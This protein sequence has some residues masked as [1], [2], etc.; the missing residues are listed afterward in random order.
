MRK[1]LPVLFALLF[2]PTRAQDDLLSLLGQ[3]S[4][5][6]EYTNASFKTTR[7]INAHSLENTAHGVLDARINHRFGLLSEGVGNFFGLDESTI[8]IGFDYGVTDRLM[9][10]IG[11]SS[12][13]KTIDG[14][15]KYKILRQCDAGC[16]M[17]VTLAVVASTAVTT[18][19]ADEVPWYE[20]GRKDYFSHRLSY[21][22]QVIL[23]R[24]FSDAFSMQIMPGSVHRNLVATVD[25]RN[26]IFN[27]GVAAR[28]K[29]LRR[30]AINTEYFYV[31]P[32]QGPRDAY[33]NSLSVGFD[34]ETGGHV[35]Q[36]HFTN[37]TG[38]FERA[39]I[40][41]T[42]GDFFKGRIHY[43]FNISRVFTLYDPKKKL[44]ERKRKEGQQ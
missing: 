37:S 1:L 38:M 18:L 24:K 19:Q 12:Y 44:R 5:V 22:F 31:L 16:T 21:S 43:G 36:L 11:R 27:V 8:R 26:D 32:D 30:L 10:G 14:F 40:T 20:E 39:F 2:L 15:A 42:S 9:I 23:G 17:P 6:K 41:E 7:V 28:Y 25:D 33:N 29:F 3:D 35:F 4:A 13:Q 34:I